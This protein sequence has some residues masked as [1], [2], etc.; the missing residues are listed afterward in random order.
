MKMAGFIQSFEN[1]TRFKYV[2]TI[3]K[4]LNCIHEEIKVRLN[5]G[6]ACYHSVLSILSSVLLSKNLK[7]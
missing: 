2:G 6:N 3:V 1:V 5:S 7:D 4:N